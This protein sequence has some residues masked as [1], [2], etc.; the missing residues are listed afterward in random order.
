MGSKTMQQLHNGES[1]SKISLDTYRSEEKRFISWFRLN[2]FFPNY[3]SFSHWNTHHMHFY[4]PFYYFKNLL[5]SVLVKL[6]FWHQKFR[7]R[8]KRWNFRLW[9]SNFWNQ[10]CVLVLLNSFSQQIQRWHDCWQLQHQL[11][12]VHV[13]TAPLSVF[14]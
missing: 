3:Q 8:G 10:S 13:P 2:I 4:I 5:F 1:N 11:P 14:T 9:P 6:T 7:W 12:L